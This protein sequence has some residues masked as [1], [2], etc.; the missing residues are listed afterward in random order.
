M[1]I[2]PRRFSEKD[3]S[4]RV[5]WINNPVV[6]RNMYFDL[7][8]TVE[9]TIQWFINNVGNKKRIDFTFFDSFGE[10]IAMGG[11]TSIDSIHCNAEF[12]VMVNPMMHGK[13][14]GK[15][16]SF[17]MYNYAFSILNL[18]KI[19]LYT[20]D[21]NINAYKIYESAGFMLEG[22]LRDHKWKN[23]KF[24]NRRI[25]GLLKSEWELLDWKEIID[26]EL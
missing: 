3:I 4:D 18:N 6:N 7:P 12:Y 16:V 2:I 22:V 1:E 26:H 10:R 20:N 9:N 11:Y 8:A 19:Y 21:D 14:I 13:G 17:W 15:K 23:G 5:D 25:Y 24:Q